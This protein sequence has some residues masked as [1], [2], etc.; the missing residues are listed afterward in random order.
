MYLL[1]LCTCLKNEMVGKGNFIVGLVK[2][3]AVSNLI[4]LA[5]AAQLKTGNTFPYNNKGILSD[6]E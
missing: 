6:A 3:E 5:S 2:A 1:P 4:L